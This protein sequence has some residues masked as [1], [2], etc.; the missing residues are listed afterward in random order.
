MRNRLQSCGIVLASSLLIS[1]SAQAA[2]VV[3]GGNGGFE[4]VQLGSPYFSTNPANVPGWTHGGSVGD[5]L[6]WNKNY[7][8]V[9]P[10][11]SGEGNQFVTMGGGFGGPNATTTWSTSITGLTAGTAYSLSFMMANEDNPFDAQAFQS[12]NVSINGSAPVT[13]TA[14][15]SGPSY[16]GDWLTETLGFTAVAGTES[17]VFT[18]TTPTDVGL[19]NVQ[20]TAGVPEPSTWAM[21]LI[22]FA[23]LGYMAF[24]RKAGVALA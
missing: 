12:I 1:V 23:G 6:I 20:V 18:A 19:D 16:W 2:P 5:A 21:M 15:Y 11:H 9:F 10:A 4:A 3:A 7:A 24:R 17:L 13:F 14:A 8:D 22:G